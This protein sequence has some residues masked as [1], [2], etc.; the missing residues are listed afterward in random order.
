MLPTL[1]MVTDQRGVPV[2]PPEVLEELDQ[3]S[4][5]N[6][7]AALIER[8]GA[9]ERILV[10]ES[11][12]W[13]ERS[14]REFSEEFGVPI[15]FVPVADRRTDELAVI[16]HHVVAKFAAAHAQSSETA[17]SGIA[18]GLMNTALRVRSESKKMALLKKALESDHSCAEARVELAD[19]HFRRSDRVNAL[20]AY[21]DVIADE[22]RRWAQQSPNW[23][24]NRATRAYLRAIYG[25][26]MT[27]W[28][29]G[30]HAAAGDALAELLRV[31]PRDHQ[32]VRFLLP[33]V[34]LLAEDYE[35]SEKSYADYAKNYPL[36]YAEPSFA[37]GRGVMHSYFGR[38]REAI[39]AYREGIFRNIYLAPIILEQPMPPETIWQPNDRADANFAREFV[40]SYSI[41]WD[42]VP[43]SRRNLREA[44]EAVMP[45]I[46]LIV[47]H[48][49][50]M[51]D[52]Q[53]Q[54]YEPD[55][56]SIW[57]KAVAEDEKL[58]LEPSTGQN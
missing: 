46:T 9:P 4:A 54:R 55:Y 18:Q 34:W 31:N 27:L 1:V 17:S 48:R 3:T 21:D 52:L 51:V 10:G 45:L 47:E 7:L 19:A 20:K 22:R 37:F 28:H 26:G 43:A 30:A 13:D 16:T 56:K 36:D 53:D 14:W 44:W 41:L 15:E 2:A 25:R 40:E 5:E 35:S 49:S 33:L 57:Q 23:W 8:L 32:G 11:E 24:S 12:E 50:Q 38:D 39:A 29:Q 42:R 6:V 58:S